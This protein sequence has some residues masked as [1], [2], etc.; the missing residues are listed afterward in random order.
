M[1]STTASSP[2][3]DDLTQKQQRNINCLTDPNRSTRRRALGKFLKVFNEKPKKNVRQVHATF[4]IQS[5]R[6]PL[7]ACLCDEVE[8]C[9]ELSTTLFTHFI[10]NV[11][12]EDSDQP[13]I[14]ALFTSIVPILKE[15]VG[16]IPF[17]EPTEEIRLVLIDLFNIFL[18]HP[19]VIKSSELQ[20]QGPDLL[21]VYARSLQDQFPDVKRSSSVGVQ[22]L[23]RVAP[24]RLHTNME[25]CIVSLIANLG[26]QHSKVRC[27]SLD[28]MAALLPTGAEGLERLMQEKVLTAFRS[29]SADRSGTVRKSVVTTA[30]ALCTSLPMASRFHAEL[31]PLVL[32]GIADEADDV[33]EHAART[34]CSLGSEVI[35]IKSVASESRGGGGAGAGEDGGLSVAAEAAGVETSATKTDDATKT[36]A[37]KTDADE[38]PALAV[39][40]PAPLPPSP[41]PHVQDESE[42][43]RLEA[44]VPTLGAPFD[45]VTPHPHAKKIVQQLLPALLPPVLRELSEWTVARRSHAAGVLSAILVFAEGSAVSFVPQILSALG[46]ACR[47]DEVTV[48]GRAFSCAELLGLFLPL[49]SVLEELLPMIGEYGAHQKKM[50]SPQERSGL[51]MIL[52]A[53][54]TSAQLTIGTSAEK[55]TGSSSRSSSRWT[56]TTAELMK[57]VV[58]TLAL[59]VVCESDA[60]EVQSQLVEVMLD[61]I[62]V[63]CADVAAKSTRTTSFAL[64]DSSSN[65]NLHFVRILVQLQATPGEEATAG[66]VR[67]GAT[68]TMIALAEACG[69]SSTSD[70]FDAHFEQLLRI[71]LAGRQEKVEGL[72]EEENEEEN[73]EKRGGGSRVE[74]VVMEEE[75]KMPKKEKISTMAR[76]AAKWIKETPQRRLF[77]TLIRQSMS[78]S[79]IKNPVGDSLHLILPILEATLQVSCD[80]DLRIGMMALIS[81][82][83]DNAYVANICRERDVYGGT[84]L[85]RLFMPNIVWRV[86]RVACS[87][88]KITMRCVS[89][90]LRHRLVTAESL[91]VLWKEPNQLGNVMKSCLDDDEPMTRQLTALALM[92]MFEVMPGMLDMVNC[93]VRF[94]FLILFCFFFFFFLAVTLT[95]GLV[96]FVVCLLF[97]LFFFF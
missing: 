12:T 72:D 28:A 77:D 55:I 34:M 47:D 41:P 90:L 63:G 92:N 59:P 56:E 53:V 33:K 11:L 3:L 94:F 5:L 81:T 57:K 83:L 45:K 68:S 6:S 13:A 9:R 96:L 60:I 10:T 95:Q 65:T 67:T 93:D 70:I 22:I 69:A 35:S 75:E 49:E 80:P 32:G 74:V 14:V 4:F 54:M 79:S 46:S 86:G 38:V 24:S 84:M 27:M 91:S 52:S 40:A 37:T 78:G 58:K 43:I 66:K 89:T 76:R 85:Q 15:R 71:I 31:L 18:Q 25:R 26:H 51:L 16:T 88:R 29:V 23:S 64:L 73:E 62:S 2:A 1:A 39:A 30:A 87:V 7:L 19:A 97:V 21:A 36:E 17:T 61:V 50:I 44:L 8:K 82:M 48:A 42:R 20:E